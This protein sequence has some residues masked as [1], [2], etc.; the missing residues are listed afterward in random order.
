MGSGQGCFGIPVFFQIQQN[1]QKILAPL[2]G[3]ADQTLVYDGIKDFIEPLD[4]ELHL[5]LHA[6]QIK[7]S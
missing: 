7:L 1:L 4:Q 3:L 5:F 6:L 2:I